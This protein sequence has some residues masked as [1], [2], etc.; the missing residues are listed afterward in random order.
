M[1]KLWRNGRWERVP[2]VERGS[3]L[4]HSEGDWGF[5]ARRWIGILEAL[6]IV[7]S[8]V[9]VP[10]LMYTVLL[11]TP[12]GAIIIAVLLY[13]Q[14]MLLLGWWHLWAG[15]AAPGVYERGVEVPWGK[16]IPY[17]EVMGVEWGSYLLGRVLVLRLRPMGRKLI[18]VRALFGDDG[19]GYVEWKLR[20][21]YIPDARGAPPRLVVYPSGDAGGLSLGEGPRGGIP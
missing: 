13:L 8:L 3:A 12:Q 19:S 9:L 2:S 15:G 16:F 7:L 4:V 6:V 20:T 17:G 5:L 18:L 10:M 1:P 21:E 14:G 11:Y